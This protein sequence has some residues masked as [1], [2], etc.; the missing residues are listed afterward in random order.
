MQ[1]K[2]ALELLDALPPDDPLAQGSRKDLQRLNTW[3]GNG[4]IMARELRTALYDRVPKHIVEIGAGDGR[5][6]HRVAS[7]LSPEWNGVRVTLLDHQSTVQP[8]IFQAFLN[9]G[10]RAESVVADVFAWL[11]KPTESLSFPLREEEG[12]S[13]GANSITA[14][15]DAIIAN[16]FVHHF[17][18]AQL[19]EMLSGV[20]RRTNCFV[21]LEPRRSALSLGFSRMV[22]LIGCNAVTRQ[23]AVISVRA[24]FCRGELSRLWPRDPGWSLHE[25]SAGPFSH[26]FIAHRN[27]SAGRSALDLRS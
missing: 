18:E 4:A 13:E 27:D 11:E 22:G 2:V 21:A 10:W 6:M 1:R 16:L 5:F 20:S 9:L 17:S 19:R 7:R 3:M 23:D 8:E 12:R 26:L 14:S 25:T 24:G 15:P